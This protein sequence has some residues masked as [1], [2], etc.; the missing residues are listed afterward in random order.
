MH[1]YDLTHMRKMYSIRQRFTFALAQI[2]VAYMQ[3]S[4]VLFKAMCTL[5]QYLLLTE[6]VQSIKIS[7]VS[8]TLFQ[9]FV[10]QKN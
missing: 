3:I 5:T 8:Q 2:S 7:S 9:T 4:K 10:A 6:V 1:V